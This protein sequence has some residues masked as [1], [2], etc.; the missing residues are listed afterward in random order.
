MIKN[1]DGNFWYP[2][3]DKVNDYDAYT[4]FVDGM[5]KP[6]KFRDELVWKIQTELSA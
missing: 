6:Y 4:D 2:I 5:P 1:I 3:P